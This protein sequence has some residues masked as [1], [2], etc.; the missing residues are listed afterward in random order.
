MLAAWCFVVMLGA[1][2]SM[3]GRITAFH[4]ANKREVFAFRRINNR[5]FSFKERVVRF[6]DDLSDPAA[7]VLVVHYADATERIPVSIPPEPRS[8]RW[9]L[10]DMLPHEDWLR[11]LLMAPRE[12]MSFEEWQRR[13]DADQLDTRLIL[14]SRV[15]RPGSDPATWGSVWKKDWVFDFHELMRD[16]TIHRHPR[17]K[18]PSTR[19]VQEPKPGEL[20]ENTWQFQAALQTMP[21]AGKIGPTHNF[22]GNAIAAAGWTLPTAAFAGLAGTVASVFAFAPARRARGSWRDCSPPPPVTTSID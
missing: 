18:Y 6:E 20:H 15:P 19:G 17:L 5:E 9:K 22:F 16:G 3:G 2:W 14:A 11:V 12:G 21:Q 13:L 8:P 1:G 4:E 10:P 7:P